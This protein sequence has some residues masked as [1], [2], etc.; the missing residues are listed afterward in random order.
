MK[1]VSNESASA[2]FQAQIL[3]KRRNVKEDGLLQIKSKKEADN[4]KRNRI[5]NIKKVPRMMMVDETKDA[6][7]VLLLE[8]CV[9][10]RKT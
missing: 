1:C 9:C 5:R 4:R 7:D 2:N 10:V 3:A 6:E 8:S